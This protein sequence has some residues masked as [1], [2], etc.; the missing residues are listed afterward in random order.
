M[1]KNFSVLYAGHVLEGDGIGFDGVP[2]NDRWYSNEQC[3]RAFDI[4]ADLAQH[5]ESL[6][7]DILWLAEHHFQ[8]EGMN[9]SPTSCG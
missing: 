4:S 8:R 2:A 5:M 6:G 3:A 7:Y 1:L 9:V